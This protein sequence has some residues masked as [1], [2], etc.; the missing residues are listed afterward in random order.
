VTQT[1]APDAYLGRTAVDPQGSKIGSVGQVYLNDQ[2]GVPDWITVN[3]G[4]FGTRENFV[5]L[6]GSRFDGDD[7]VLPF[8]KDV[9]KDAPDIDDASHLDA[10]EQQNLY[11]YYSQYLTGQ[12]AADAGT[13][14]GAVAGDD[15]VTGAEGGYAAERGEAAGYD[16]S[17]PTTDEAMTRSE[18]QLQVGTQQVETGRARLRKYVVT[19]DQT[20]TVPVSHEE[21]RIEREPITDGNRDAALSGADISEEEHEV[22]LH[23]ERPVVA[24]EAVP[25]ER[26]RLGT[27]TVTDQEQVTAEVR[28]EQIELT[29]DTDDAVPAGNA[30]SGAVADQQRR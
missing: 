25:V 11:S 30:D 23:A 7:L 10:D 2:S 15:A 6:Q 12:G 29:G 18:E 19:E 22:V 14:G 28:K 16:T 9:V 5:P 17:G 20:V 1:I 21:V 27:D 8:G 4:L 24:T 3:T 26:V 13:G